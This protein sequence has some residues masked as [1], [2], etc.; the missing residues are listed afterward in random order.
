MFSPILL[1]WKIQGF[2]KKVES[3]HLMN[4]FGKRAIYSKIF[5]DYMNT[6][7]FHANVLI[8]ELQPA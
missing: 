7:T 2:Q 1:D 5:I 6:I 4:I 8:Q 3:I